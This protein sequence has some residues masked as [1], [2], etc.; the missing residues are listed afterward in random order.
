MDIVLGL[1]KDPEVNEWVMTVSKDGRYYEP[2]Y[3]YTNDLVDA[4][5]T[6]EAE[7]Q[8][9]ADKGHNVT[10]TKTLRDLIIRL[11]SETR[12]AGGL[13]KDLPEDL[14]FRAR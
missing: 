13:I 4:V 3:N 5:L 1:K 8:A 2:S 12:K 14:K 6:A 9:Y 10:Y 11:G 7:G